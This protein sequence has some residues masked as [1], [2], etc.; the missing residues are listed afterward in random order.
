[1]HLTLVGIT[2]VGHSVG[3]FSIWGG[4]FLYQLGILDYSGGYVIHLSS[5]TAGFVA[6]AWVGPRLQKDKD[7]FPPNNILLAM[8]GAGILWCGWNGFNG[9]DP[10][11]AS[12]DAGVAVLN[13]N[14]CTA[15]S[16][17]VWMA[18]D[19]IAFKKPSMTGAIQGEITGL[20]V[21][22]PAAGFV[23]GWGAIILGIC[24]VS[25]AAKSCAMRHRV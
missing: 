2:N 3:A 20:V 9:G 1:M 7:Y 11:T 24:S 25:Y 17:L 13:T 6:A 18:L 19:V 12:P 4:G 22:T 16:F 15:I 23:A 14:L 8:V 21:I 10:Y 5:G